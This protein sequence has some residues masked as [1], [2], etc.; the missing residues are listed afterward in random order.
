MECEPRRWTSFSQ[1]FSRKESCCP[2]CAVETVALNNM[3]HLVVI[4]G[5]KANDG[6]IQLEG[7]NKKIV[8]PVSLQ[9]FH[10]RVQRLE[11]FGISAE[12]RAHRISFVGSAR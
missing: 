10:V 12:V 5:G 9:P 7:I 11:R 3:N 8:L 2:L 6:G 4:E 1:G